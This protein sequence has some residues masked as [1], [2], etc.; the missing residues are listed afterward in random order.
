MKM[1]IITTKEVMDDDDKAAL[2]RSW[3][4]VRD[5]INANIGFAAWLENIGFTVY[6]GCKDIME[7]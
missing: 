1:F 4:V 6:Y 2:L 3:L 7:A 5:K